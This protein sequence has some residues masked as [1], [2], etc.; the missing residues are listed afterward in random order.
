MIHATPC[1]TSYNCVF[2][3]RY[4]VSGVTATIIQTSGHWAGSEA[5]RELSKSLIIKY[6]IFLLTP[7]RPWAQQPLINQ[8]LL[9]IEASRTHC[10]T[11]VGRTP[12]DGWSARRKELYLITHK[13]HNRQTSMPPAGFEP[14]VPA[15]ERPHT[16]ALDRPATGIGHIFPTDVNSLLRISKVGTFGMRTR[17][18]VCLSNWLVVCTY[19]CTLAPCVKYSNYITSTDGDRNT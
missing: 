12:L 2:E 7:A 3:C 13:T 16:D 11:T 4:E 5:G 15:S 14:A 17:V 1:N 10:R 9:V 19:G 18:F 8:R 6:H